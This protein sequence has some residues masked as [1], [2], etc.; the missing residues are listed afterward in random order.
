VGTDTKRTPKVNK[1][2]LEPLGQ[3]GSTPPPQTEG[4]SSR[5]N[6]PIRAGDRPLPGA[7]KTTGASPA[8][9]KGN[10]PLAEGEKLGKF[11]PIKDRP[12]PLVAPS[13]KEIKENAEET[14]LSLVMMANSA[15]ASLVDDRARMT[16]PE[17]KIIAASLAR[18]LERMPPDQLENVN[19]YSDPLV[20]G[21]AVLAW[22][23]RVI[24]IA[25][26]QAEARRIAAGDFPELEYEQ[27]PA[28]AVPARENGF[29]VKPGMPGYVPNVAAMARAFEGGNQYVG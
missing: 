26:E 7:T 15:A 19:K 23:T 28:P 10:P 9:D 5:R 20:L 29:G 1:R 25:R 14:A 21:T 12:R 3:D 8:S 18:M 24:R 16:K 4:D 11:Q 17:E 13:E 22:L 6:R 2:Y 27:A